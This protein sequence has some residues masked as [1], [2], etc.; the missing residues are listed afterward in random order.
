VGFLR[1]S[2]S[3]TTPGGDSR[4]RVMPTATLHESA[5]EDSRDPDAV[6]D[7]VV[8]RVGELAREPGGK[9]AKRRG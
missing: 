8:Q 9:P 5:V 7:G 1:P 4:V 2:G 3:G 6:R